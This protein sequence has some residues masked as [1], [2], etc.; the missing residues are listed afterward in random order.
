MSQPEA[1]SND[2]HPE[3]PAV[4]G[5]T[6]Y[7]GG[8]Y[9]TNPPLPVRTLTTYKELPPYTDM[10]SWDMLPIEYATNGRCD[11]VK[12]GPILGEAIDE[13]ISIS[14]CLNFADYSEILYVQL[15]QNDE[16]PWVYLVKHKDGYYVCFDAWCDYTGFSCRGVVKITYS[17]NRENMLQFGL[18]EKMRDSIK[19]N[20]NYIAR[21]ESEDFYYIRENTMFAMERD[22][23][24]G[25]VPLIKSGG[26][27]EFTKTTL[28]ARPG[29]FV[30]SDESGWTLSHY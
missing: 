24:R 6:G 18:D 3:Q 4:L 22:P 21:G 14:S 5:Y 19:N 13:S 20:V 27:L 23:V 1:I 11:D 12:F 17:R 10:F 15:G 28:S 25:W 2:Y 26:S 16:Q 7:P 9:V 8:Q 29:Y 30:W